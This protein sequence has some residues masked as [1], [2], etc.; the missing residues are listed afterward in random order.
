MAAF[1]FLTVGGKV[2]IDESLVPAPGDVRWEIRSHGPV[3]PSVTR[4]S[5]YPENG[6]S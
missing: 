1:G 6:V 3:P 2:S 4:L 5:W